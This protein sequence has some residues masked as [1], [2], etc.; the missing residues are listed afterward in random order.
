[1]QITELREKIQRSLPHLS[2][3]DLMRVATF[4]E[5]LEQQPDEAQQNSELVESRLQWVDQ[6]R[7]N[8]AHLSGSSG[9]QTVLEMRQEERY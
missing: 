5:S 9:K 8:R 6:L 4:I 3:Q 7:Q 2:P 1:M